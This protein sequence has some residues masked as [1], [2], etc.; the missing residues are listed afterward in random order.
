MGFFDIFHCF[1][2]DG[3]GIITDDDELLDLMILDELDEEDEE[4]DDDM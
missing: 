3:D 2:T 4:D 1:D